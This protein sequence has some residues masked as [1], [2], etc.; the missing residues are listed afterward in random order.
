MKEKDFTGKD[1]YTKNLLQKAGLETPSADFT[2]RLMEKIQAAPA[3]HVN[4]TPVISI[5]GWLLTAVIFTVICLVVIFTPTTPGS[6]LPGIANY[7]EGFR[8]IFS[9]YST[10]FL[11][12]I[13]SLSSLSVLAWVVASGWLL[14]GADKLIRKF[15]VAKM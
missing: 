10:G 15:M 7:V 9:G 14:Y 12:K 11:D 6:S 3:S 1:D 8:F 5:K 2:A 4:Y 13:Y